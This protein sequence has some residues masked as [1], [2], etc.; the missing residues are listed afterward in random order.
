MKKSFITIL[1]LSGIVLISFYFN[2]DDTYQV[3]SKNISEPQNSKKANVSD[4]QQPEAK[5]NN[6][7]TGQTDSATLLGEEQLTIN[8]LMNNQESMDDVYVP[9]VPLTEEEK[10]LHEKLEKLGHI[11]PIEYYNYGL[12]TLESLAE[13]GDSNA[14]F[15]LGERYYYQLL[16]D[17]AH[18]D[19]NDSIDYKA[20]ARDAFSKALYLGNRHAAAVISELNMIEKNHEDAYSWHLLAEDLGDTPATEWFKHQEFYATITED[21]KQ[22]AYEKYEFLKQRFQDQWLNEGKESLLN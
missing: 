22:K 17:P 16:N 5:E 1:L 12:D 7:E 19:Y 13:N 21:Q 4:H 9:P 2:F 11:I 8:D 14:A 10:A 3:E 20:A 6:K 15:H 18:M